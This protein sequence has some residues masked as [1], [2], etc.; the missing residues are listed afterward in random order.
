[1]AD[2]NVE[3]A[4]VISDAFRQ[5]ESTPAWAAALEL[6]HPEMEMDTTRLPIPGLARMCRGVD[7]IGRFWI[8]WLQ[9][10]ESFGSFDEPEL[11]DAGDQVV[12]WQT[13]QRIRGKGSGIEI[14]MPDY[15]WVITIR[16][17]KVMRAT[18]Y[19]DKAE[20]L[21]SVGLSE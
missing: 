9:A 19:L 3:V 4:R 14:E 20:A 11:I 8:E 13:D 16:D 15:A 7:E 21:E 10:W 1:M 17:R 18:L 12:A 2:D 6:L 5:G